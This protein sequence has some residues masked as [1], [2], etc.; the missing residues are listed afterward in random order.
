M[1]LSKD[2]VILQQDMPL[3]KSWLWDMQH[4]FF[5]REGINAWVN[6]VPF[7]ITSNPYIA[8]SYANIIIRFMQDRVKRGSYNPLEPF[9]IIEL[10]AGS[11]KFSFYIIKRLMELRHQLGMETI[12]FVYVMTDFTSKN[13]QYWKDHPALQ[14]YIQQKILDFAQYNA[15]KM[16]PIQLINSGIKLGHMGGQ[17]TLNPIIAIANYVFDT[18]PHDVFQIKDD[19]LAEGIVALSTLKQHIQEGKPIAPGYIRTHFA[20]QPVS[21]DYYQQPDIDAVLNYYKRSYD[22][23]NLLFPIGSLRCLQNLRQLSQNELLVLATDKG[24]TNYLNEYNLADPYIA[25]HGSFSLLVNFH[26]LGQYFKYWGGDCYYQMIQQNIASCAFIMG[27]KFKELPETYQA[28]TAYFDHFGPGNLFNIYTDSKLKHKR[29][30]QALLGYLN[31]SLWDPEVF[32]QLAPL[33]A[34]Q[35]SQSYPREQSDLIAILPHIAANYYYIPK[36]CNTLFSI[37]L[38][39]QNIGKYEAA[40]S[41][42]KQALLYPDSNEHFTTYYNMGICSHALNKYQD[43]ITMFSYAV[44]LAPDDI[45]AQG[46]LL[47]TRSQYSANL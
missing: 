5:E 31:T 28:L 20:Y 46:W 12:S 3:S 19:Q 44:K 47:K 10:G 11:G 33:I 29:S 6:Q 43:A 4:E 39:L 34:E 36:G 21:S 38:L 42:Y 14:P 16:Q 13:I 24:F 37:G 45:L 26:A 30:L 27:S 41:Y 32:E 18:V 8:N 9:Y 1:D 35:M 22:E 7:Y 2:E 15:T 25:H 23:I 40:I 17:T